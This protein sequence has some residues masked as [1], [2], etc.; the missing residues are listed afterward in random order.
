M[1]II[2]KRLFLETRAISMVI[3]TRENVFFG[4]VSHVTPKKRILGV[5]G[6]M[7]TTAGSVELNVIP[8]ILTANSRESSCHMTVKWSLLVRTHLGRDG[9]LYFELAS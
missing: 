3:T 9:N 4:Q 1:N 6:I 2:A 8:P 7:Q 5:H